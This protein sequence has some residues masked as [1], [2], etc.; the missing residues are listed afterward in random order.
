MNEKHILK[1]NKKARKKEN[2]K[3][4]AKAVKKDVNPNICME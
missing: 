4:S 1:D 3:I 2:N